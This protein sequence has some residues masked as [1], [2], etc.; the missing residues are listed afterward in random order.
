MTEQL[1]GLFRRDL[2]RLTQELRAFPDGATLWQTVPGVTNSAG[3][4][5][6]HLE[7]NLREYIG[8][9]LGSLPYTRDRANEFGARG[10]TTADLIARVEAVTVMVPAVVAALAPETLDSLYP[11]S[12]PGGPQSTKQFLLSLYGHLNYHLGQIGYLRR[13]LTA[14]KPRESYE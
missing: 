11:D 6:L 14:G 3:N 12:L 5:T 2:G 13:V 9:L 1:A 4:L 8:R 7:G 10:L